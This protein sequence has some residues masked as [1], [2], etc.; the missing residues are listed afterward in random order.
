M[1]KRTLAVASA[2][3]SLA[4]A[5]VAD[6]KTPT[7]SHIRTYNKLRSHIVRDYGVQ[8]VGRNIVKH[9]LSSGRKAS[10]ADI[11][12]SIGVM[13]RMI[14]P[15]ISSPVSTYTT[16]T[17]TSTTAVQAP[18]SSSGLE[19]C[20]VYRES[21]NNPQATNG[22]YEGYGQWSP[23]QWAADGGT[24]YAPTPLGASP[25]EQMQ[26]LS[27]EGTAGMLTQQGQYDGCA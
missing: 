19:Q 13:E 3:L 1:L 2:V 6:A 7:H 22:Q 20:I 9:G 16:T 15:R 12:K 27:S 4:I 17:Y 14:A 21:T 11:V 23:Q 26:I 25:S 18:I 24:K 8:A 10:D 5:P